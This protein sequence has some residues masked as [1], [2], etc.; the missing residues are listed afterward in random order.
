MPENPGTGKE[1]ERLLVRLVADAN[2][3]LRAFDEAQSKV[4]EVSNSVSSDVRKIAEETKAL[5]QATLFSVMMVGRDLSQA[6]GGL[7]RSIVSAAARFEDTQVTFEAMIGN[8]NLAKRFIEDLTTFSAKTPYEMPTLETASKMLLQYG[9]SVSEVIPLL[10]AIGDVTGGESYRVMNM[11][12]AFGQMRSAGRLMGQDLLQMINAGFNPLREIAKMTGKTIGE[13][14]EEM[15]KGAITSDMVTEAFMRAGERLNLMEKRSQTLS[16]RLSTL[17]DDYQIFLRHVGEETQWAVSIAVDALSKLVKTLDKLNPAAKAVVGGTIH[18]ATGTAMAV[19]RAGQFAFAAGA[20]SASLK[21]LW[22]YLQPITKAIFSLA[23][24]LVTVK[25]LIVAAFAAMVGGAIYFFHPSALQLREE[26]AAYY[27]AEAAAAK[28][29][30]EATKSYNKETQNLI[31]S[32]SK[33]PAWQAKS[34]AQSLSTQAEKDVDFYKSRI[35]SLKKYIDSQP[36]YSKLVGNTSLQEANRELQLMEKLFAAAE[37]RA[38]A[39]ADAIEKIPTPK[40]AFEIGQEKIEQIAEKTRLSRMT[41]EERL[42]YQAEKEAE[43][44]GGRPLLP[45]EREMLIRRSTLIQFSSDVE[46][47]RNRIESFIKEQQKAIAMSQ[48]PRGSSES[49]WKLQYEALEKL[50][51]YGMAPKW[52]RSYLDQARQ[53]AEEADH[54]KKMASLGEDMRRRAAEIMEA[55]LPASEKFAREKQKLDE[56][57]ASGNINQE[58]YNVLLE[59]TRKRLFQVANQ[60]QKAGEAIQAL[61]YRTSAYYAMRQTRYLGTGSLA[62]V[63]T[64]VTATPNA[65]VGAK[66]LVSANMASNRVVELLGGIY[67]LA[68][69]YWSNGTN[70]TL[71]PAELIS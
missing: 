20:L 47:V 61:G 16:G 5:S 45:N 52:L 42:I 63:K 36:W 12:Y 53:A 10:R 33:I 56:V 41:P 39:L 24:A 9:V 7:S 66:P 67:R 46:A 3:F 69:E 26:Y 23:G 70:V 27:N 28:R 29:A 37:S 68:E 8:A 55:S 19:E 6:F 38:K 54:A 62:S 30:E 22:V 14:R 43:A 13:V 32:I 51:R 59:E 17:R 44:T 40:T 65:Q 60:A 34:Y 2:Q 21:K 58:E 4:K 11:A 71:E 15:S 64:N 31:S 18:L 57:L 50:E 48:A 25:A 49:F 35:E 1:I